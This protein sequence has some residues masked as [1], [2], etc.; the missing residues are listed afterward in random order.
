[1]DGVRRG[2]TTCRA[3]HSLP[4][5]METGDSELLVCRTGEVECRELHLPADPQLDVPPPSDS[6]N[7]GGGPGGVR[8][9]GGG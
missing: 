5:T 4:V 8:G 1:M 6:S 3:A 9:G 7:S 2:I